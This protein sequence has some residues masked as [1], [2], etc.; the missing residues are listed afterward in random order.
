VVWHALISIQ[1][2]IIVPLQHRGPIT[3]VLE[4]LLLLE[5]DRGTALDSGLPLPEPLALA[6]SREFAGSV[7]CLYYARRA[8]G[9]EAGVATAA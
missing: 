2:M 5:L 7:L 9:W 1:R 6:V 3:R 4:R 8:E